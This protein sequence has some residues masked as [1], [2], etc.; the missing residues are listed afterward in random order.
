MVTHNASAM[1]KGNLKE[2]NGS[3]HLEKGKC[4]QNFNSGSRFAE[5]QGSNPEEMIGAA[6]A[7]CFS[8]ALSDSLSQAGHEPKRIDTRAAVKLKTG[9][10]GSRIKSIKLTTEGDVPGIDAEEFNKYAAD[11]KDNCTVSKAL[12][13]VDISVDATLKS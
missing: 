11:A 8:M 4:D 7:G 12:S 9:D 5:G 1:W 2:G 10:G 6:H 3:M 13:G